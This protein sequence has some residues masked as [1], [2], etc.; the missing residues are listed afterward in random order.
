MTNK[1]MDRVRERNAQVR[2]IIIGI[3]VLIIIICCCIF[4]FGS[5]G[6]T[7]K[8]NEESTGTPDKTV[9]INAG[10]IKVY[11]DEAKYYLYTAQ[12]TYETYYLTEEKEINWKKKTKSGV[13][14]ES[15]V[16]STVLDE[17]CR[18]ECMYSYHDEYG[19]SLSD[20]EKNQISIKLDNYY[21]QTKG[22]LLSKIG[23][24]KARLKKVFEKQEI[25]KKVENVMAF[26]DENLPDEMY[27][28][29]KKANT[30]TANSGWE[31]INFDE[32]IFTLEDVN[33][34][35]ETSTH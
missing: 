24:E 23:I 29:W 2:K 15:L 18:R 25:A 17:I 14:M 3:C 31:K 34:S 27:N 32:P 22:E 26:K 21:S 1:R 12:G 8:K 28:N 10:D 16:K 6:T 33:G 13:T 9:A 19:V 5:C 35:G 30:V 4:A 7:T 11:L 20:E